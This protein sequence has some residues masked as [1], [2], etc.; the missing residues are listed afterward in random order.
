MSAQEKLDKLNE[1]W[2]AAYEGG[3]T[4]ELFID[5]LELLIEQAQEE[6]GA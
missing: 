4:K 2:K 6:L 5:L 3:D 1:L